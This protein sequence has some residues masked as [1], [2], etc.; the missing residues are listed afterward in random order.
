MR[1]VIRNVN[2]ILTKISKFSHE[3]IFHISFRKKTAQKSWDRSEAQGRQS[4]EK[5]EDFNENWW[6]LKCFLTWQ[7]SCCYF[8]YQHIDDRKKGSRWFINIK[9]FSL[10]PKSS[11]KLLFLIA[12]LFSSQYIKSFADFFQEWEREREDI[13]IKRKTPRAKNRRKM[14]KILGGASMMRRRS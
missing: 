4:T 6:V 10:S 12:K 9:E 13:L 5:S 14:R 1:Q 11:A 7:R 8:R 2:K 3:R